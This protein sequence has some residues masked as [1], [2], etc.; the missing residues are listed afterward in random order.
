M[1]KQFNIPPETI[2]RQARASDPRNSVWVSANAGSGKTHVLA[3]RVIRLLLEGTDPSKILC[4]TYT[5]AAAANMSN[6]V[7]S[8]LS[9]WTMLDDDSLTEAIARLDGTR[10]GAGKLRRARRLFAQALETPGGLKIQTIHAFC[11]SVLHQFP[12]EANIAAHFEMLD[13][14]MEEALVAT[15]RREMITGAVAAENP[16]LGE[17]FA[18][19]LERGGEFGLDALLREIVRNRDGL[20]AFID[21]VGGSGEARS[22]LLPEFEFSAD[23]SPDSIAGKVW[24]L[25]DFPPAVFADFV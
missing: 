18:T 16:E 24:P 17:A 5:R 21:V 13:P 11:A 9:S 1:K 19:V 7:F 3:Q 14:L 22:M 2:D 4:L 25:P 12:L 20:R 6:R 8:S 15:A 23:E 10:P